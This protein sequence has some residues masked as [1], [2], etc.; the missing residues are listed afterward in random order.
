MGSGAKP[1]PKNDFDKLKDE[2]NDFV[3]IVLTSDIFLAFCCRGSFKIRGAL[4]SLM[5]TLTVKEALH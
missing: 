5:N 2:R 3:G 1:Q 4:F